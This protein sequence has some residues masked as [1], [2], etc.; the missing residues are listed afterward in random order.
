[1]KFKLKK[2]FNKYWYYNIYEFYYPQEE[3]DYIFKYL[4]FD[5][6]NKDCDILFCFKHYAIE[7]WFEE[8]YENSQKG[9]EW[10]KENWGKGVFK[11]DVYYPDKQELKTIVNKV[12]NIKL[13]TKE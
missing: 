12:I 5:K 8:T 4:N 2:T 1:M 13:L 11:L 3:Y 7:Q 10:L 6:L 9:N